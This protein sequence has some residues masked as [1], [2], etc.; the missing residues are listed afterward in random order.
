MPDDL[1]FSFKVYRD[2]FHLFH[3]DKKAVVLRGEQAREFKEALEL[4]DFSDLQQLMARLT[5]NFKRGNERL[6]KNHVRNRRF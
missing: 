6:A 5:G 1:G 2:E 3:H 4:G